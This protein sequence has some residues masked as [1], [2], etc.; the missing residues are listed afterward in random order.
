MLKELEPNKHVLSAML[1]EHFFESRS[2]LL[3]VLFALQGKQSQHDIQ[4]LLEMVRDPGFDPRELKDLT[5]RDIVRLCD[6]Q[7]P[8][9]PL[10]QVT[11]AKTRTTKTQVAVADRPVVT[12]LPL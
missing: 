7:L 2:V 6:K 4:A 9:I 11:C 5:G 1:K 3:L 8:L 10:T 12:E